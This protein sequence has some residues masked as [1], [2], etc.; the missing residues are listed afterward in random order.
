MLAQQ[1]HE[2]ILTLLKKDGNV[3]TADL[4]NRMGVSSETVRKD[5]DYLEKCGQ[6]NR[7]HGGAVP[8]PEQ[9][10]APPLGYIALQTRNT[11]HIEQKTAIAEYALTMVQEQQVIALD[12][13]STSQMMALALK[14]QFQH[15][16]IVTNSI[17]NALILSD[18]PG[19]TIIL[20]G[21]ILNKNE[22]TLVDNMTPLMEHLHID[23]Y[24]MSVSGIDP[25]I[26]CTDLGFS[27]ANIQN[28]MR[29]TAAKTIV[30][31]DSSKFGRA[32]LVKV[33]PISE[34]SC[35]ITDSE[36]SADMKKAFA[37]HA[38]NLVVV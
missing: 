7:V 14:K 11:Q 38:V 17:Q 3:H 33:C 22:Y 21:G 6:L 18:C 32:S 24:F 34:V 12:Y 30:L 15:L 35:I 2:M 1:R 5:L 19:Y 28:W 20:T 23:I 25:V 8:I 26:G 16:T 9:E 37:Q 27:E 13:G 31:A 4:V 36:L 10:A 29:H